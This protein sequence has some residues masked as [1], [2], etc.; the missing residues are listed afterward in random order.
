MRI[1]YEIFE[2]DRSLDLIPLVEFRLLNFMVLPYFYHTIVGQYGIKVKKK[3]KID[4]NQ[5][6]KI[7][8]Q[9]NFYLLIESDANVR[10]ILYFR[11]A[12]N[13]ANLL[14]I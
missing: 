2:N 14:C 9:L 6:F 8:C 1:K 5:N 12:K 7:I 13:F 4:F 10:E 3:K 11:F